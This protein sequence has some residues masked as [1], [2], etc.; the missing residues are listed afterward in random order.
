MCIGTSVSGGSG[1]RVHGSDLARIRY[2]KFGILP[3]GVDAPGMYAGI[4]VCGGTAYITDNIIARQQ[5]QGLYVSDLD[6]DDGK[7][8]EVSVFTNVFRHCDQAVWVV[9]Q[10][11]CH[12]GD[13]GNASTSD[14]GG[15]D[16]RSSNTWFI[17]NAT[18]DKIKAEG[19]DFN[20]TDKALINS[21]IFDGLDCGDAGFVDFVPFVGGGAA[22]A[23]G[24]LILAGTAAAPAGA[25][26]QRMLWNGRSASGTRVPAGRYLVRLSARQAGGEQA[27]AICPLLLR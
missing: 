15:N 12:L 16:F 27:S 21:K 22:P 17:G 19:N 4:H 23:G 3:S 11:I 14:D 20:T 9:G 2:N 6:S 18:S 10:A 8:T 26:T 7:Q 25:G 1:I 5:I 13:L 24:S